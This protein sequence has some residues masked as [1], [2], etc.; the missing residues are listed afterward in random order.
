MSSR[1]LVIHGH[2]YQPPRENPW[3]LAIEPQDSAAPFENWNQ[4]INRECYAPNCQSRLLDSRGRIERLV[5]NYEYLSFNFGP[6]LLSWL[7]QADPDTYRRIIAADKKAAAERGGHGPALA[8]VYNHIIMPLAST[9]DRLTQIRWGV[10]DF[11][12]RFGRWPEGLWLAETAVDL[13]TLK[14]LAHEGLKFT[15]LSQTQA[16]AIRPLAKRKA[17]EKGPKAEAKLGDDGDWLDV[18]DGRIDPR[19]PYR[20]F[21]GDG[22]SDY[23][24]VFFYDGPVSRAIAFER[25]LSDGRTFL[26]RITSAFGQPDP[27]GR[28]RLVNLA[29]D[30]ESYGHHFPFGD[31]ALAWLFNHLEGEADEEEAIKLTNYGQYLEMFPPTKE[32]RIIDNTAWSCAHGLERWR[33]DC[34]CGAGGGDGAW[35]HKW[36]TP[37]REGLNHLRDRLAEIFETEGA[38]LLKDPWL[39]RDEYIHVL[40]SN[41]NPEARRNFLAAHQIR[42]LSPAEAGRVWSLLES[43][44]M[45]LYMFTSCAWFFDDIAGLEPV[46]NLRYALRAIELVQG[47][48]RADL[49]GELSGYLEAIK[50]NNPDYST[51]L[52]VWRKLVVPSSLSGRLL[53]AHW[54]AATIL[55]VPQVLDFFV[56]PEFKSQTVTHLHGEGLEILAAQVQLTDR[57]LD[58]DDHHLCLAI[59]SGGTHLAILAGESGTPGSDAAQR[60]PEWLDE[61]KLRA[62]LGESLKAPAALSIWELMIKLMPLTTRYVMEDLLPHC[63]GCL[64]S[65]LVG[66]IY[67]NLKSRAQDIFHL[68]QHLLMMNR[69]TGQ[70]INWVERFLFRVRGEYELK[71]IL[72]PSDFDRPIN[73]AA[74]TNLLHRRGLIGLARDDSLVAELGADFM[75]NCFS[76][77]VRS[78]TRHRHLAEI[79]GFVRLIRAENFTVDFW[80]SQNQWFVLAH[81]KSFLRLL[82]SEEKALLDDLGE[83]L[84]F[85]PASLM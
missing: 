35:N 28:P 17:D 75:R 20:V 67:E 56:V 79:L 66:D 8:Q 26:D 60:T 10:E 6:T 36:R 5:N 30:G 43:Q 74:L 12:A 25:L 70:P 24:D 14:W 44:L 71:R 73:L 77:L 37:L 59:Y 3:I 68:H 49:V 54:A 58:L 38:A 78:E 29:T 65:N 21:W 52:E 7:A 81:N 15:V 11:A 85:A 57:R 72:G 41:Y 18:S 47:L 82:S 39:A 33:S 63:R 22:P 84:G 48:T 9:R 50:P 76:G 1:Y 61:K 13:E 53:T 62:A 27:D 64:L 32:A 69:A 16:A 42:P 34:G 2:F 55:K 23:L 4:R 45:S 19:E 83:A 31:M 40:V 80:E 51:G 46:Q